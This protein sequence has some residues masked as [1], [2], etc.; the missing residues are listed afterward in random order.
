MFLEFG[1]VR[2]MKR[3]SGSKRADVLRQT[4]LATQS[5]SMQPSG[6]VAFWG[7]QTIFLDPQSL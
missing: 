1:I 2:E 7:L 3:E 6:H 5:R 4:Y